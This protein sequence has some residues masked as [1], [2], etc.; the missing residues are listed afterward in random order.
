MAITRTEVTN[1]GSNLFEGLEEDVALNKHIPNNDG[2]MECTGIY[3]RNG[4]KLSIIDGNQDVYRYDGANK[5]WNI[6]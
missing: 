4:D 1:L 5:V 3:L 6:S 2:L